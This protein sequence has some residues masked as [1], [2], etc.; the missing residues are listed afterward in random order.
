GVGHFAPVDQISLENWHAVIETNLSGVFYCVRA[1]VPQMKQ[2]GG[3]FI[4]NIGSLAGRNTFPNG[5]VY[6][7]SKFGLNGFSEAI[8][9]DLRQ[10]NIRVSQIMP[11]SVATEFMPGGSDA[12]EWK[13]DPVAIADT[14]V[15]LV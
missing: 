11:G 13:I 6:N 9:L 14:A 2:R 5:S 12:A 4:L 8:M 3:G 10:Y 1:A 15:D 7:A